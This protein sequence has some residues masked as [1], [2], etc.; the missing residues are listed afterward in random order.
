MKRFASNAKAATQEQ[1]EQ[2][3]KQLLKKEDL[4]VTKLP[5][6]V[7]VASI[8]NNSPITKLLAVVNAGSR[9]EENDTLGASHVLRA[10]SNLVSMSTRA[11]GVDSLT[12]SSSN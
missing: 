1:A 7:V 8:E 5:N 10:A 11:N 2:V 4:K 9:N 3:Q 12:Y 6:G